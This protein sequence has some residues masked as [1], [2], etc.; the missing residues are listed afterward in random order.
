MKIAVYDSKNKDR[1]LGHYVYTGRIVG[2][3][4]RVSVI[5]PVY[6]SSYMGGGRSH[7]TFE[8]DRRCHGTTRQIDQVTEETVTITRK[9]F[10]TD[11]PLAELMKLRDFRLPDETVGEAVMRQKTARRSGY[12]TASQQIMD[13]YGSHPAFRSGDY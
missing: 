12:P 1:L 2:K 3:A 6:P 5:G 10:I 13:E 11:I 4:V 7:I 8:V 9:C